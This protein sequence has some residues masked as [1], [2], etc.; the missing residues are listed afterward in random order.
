MSICLNERV[1]RP[2]KEPLALSRATLKITR[3]TVSLNL[4]CVSYKRLPAFDLYL[5]KLG[6]SATHPVSTIPLE[7]STFVR[8]F[9]IV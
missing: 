3:L 8:V 7:P 6:K 4:P 1:M 2:L 9:C 5:I